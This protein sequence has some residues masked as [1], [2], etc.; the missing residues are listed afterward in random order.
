M[1]L[2]A[3]ESLGLPRALARATYCVSDL[4]GSVATTSPA[5]ASSAAYIVVSRLRRCSLHLAATGDWT[6]A[7]Q[8][9]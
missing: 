8:P 2:R 9:D 6:V 1:P 5:G 7:S 3:R 4:A